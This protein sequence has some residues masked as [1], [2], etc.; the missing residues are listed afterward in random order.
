MGSVANSP[1][2]LPRTSR[3]SFLLTRAASLHVIAE[4]KAMADPISS[5]QL[6]QREIDRTFGD[7]Y[8]ANHPDLV[9]ATMQ[10]AASD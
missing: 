10:S 7:G 3:P 4:G 9:A 1:I 5:L 8:A 6:V 2:L